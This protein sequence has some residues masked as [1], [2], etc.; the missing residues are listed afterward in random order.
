MVMNNTFVDV[1]VFEYICWGH[2][3]L[4]G[5]LIVRSDATGQDIAQNLM[6]PRHPFKAAAVCLAFVRERCDASSFTI[7][8]SG[9]P[10]LLDRFL[11][12]A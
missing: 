11:T 8:G 7:H 3:L 9:L 6:M 4:E 10:E 2:R 1:K 5:S 12:F